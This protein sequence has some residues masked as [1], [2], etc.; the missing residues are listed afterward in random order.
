VNKC[1]GCRTS[2]SPLSGTKR[3]FPIR[4]RPLLPLYRYMGA[5]GGMAVFGKPTRRPSLKAGPL[6]SVRCSILRSRQHLFCDTRPAA[7]MGP[8]PWDV[9]SVVTALSTRMAMRG[10]SR[11]SAPQRP[12]SDRSINHA[13]SRRIRPQYGKSDGAK[14]ARPR[15]LGASALKRP[16][17]SDLREVGHVEAI[18]A[19][20]SL[21]P[22]GACMDARSRSCCGATGR[23]YYVAM[24]G[25]SKTDPPTRRPPRSRH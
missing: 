20:L 8:L 2:P 7:P 12:A 15:D 23:Q 13:L 25:P 18:R 14:P 6:P 19:R 22:N 5:H 24:T 17:V 16:S 10:R 11:P 3:R 9:R 21:H 1:P 4:C